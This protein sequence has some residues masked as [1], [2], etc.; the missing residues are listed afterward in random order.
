MNCTNVFIE[1]YNETIPSTIVVPHYAY[2]DVVTGDSFNVTAA[3]SAGGPESSPLPSA[4]SST[5]T[6]ATSTPATV[7]GTTFISF[8]GP[9]PS[10]FV[11]STSTPITVIA[12][13]KK[14]NLGAIIGGA[15]GGVAFLGIVVGLIAFI[16]LR[17]RRR[18]AAT[19]STYY[20]AVTSPDINGDMKY[21]NSINS[22]G[23]LYNPNDP[24]TFPSNPVSYSTYSGSPLPV[25]GSVPT[26]Y[27]GTPEL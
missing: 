7:T 8:G 21:N 16:F 14:S 23:R 1:T 20:S 3:E 4:T 24:S 18:P 19:P 12:T 27:A 15:V 17:R 22:P 13:S 25:L 11:T 10:P 2:L 6:S 5:S 9:E 26:H